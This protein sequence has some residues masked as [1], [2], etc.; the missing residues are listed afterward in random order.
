MNPRLAGAIARAES[1]LASLATIESVVADLRAVASGVSGASDRSGAPTSALAD[2]AAP[3]AESIESDQRTDGSW[4]GSL[5][6]TSLTLLMIR[7]LR[8]ERTNAV[9]RAIE[10]V[11]A[12]SEGDG[13]FGDLPGFFSPAPPSIDLSS[14]TLP[15]GAAIGGD[16]DAR[17]AVSCLACAAVVCWG[18]RGPNI[19]SH[20]REAERLVQLA[21][22]GRAEI[23]LPALLCAVR[24]FCVMDDSSTGSADVAATRDAALEFVARSQRGDGSWRGADLFL[25]LD[26]LADAARSQKAPTA[27]Y[28]AL[29]HASDTLF[30]MQQQ[31]GSWGRQTG[32]VQMLAGLSALRALHN[33][34]PKVLSEI[35]PI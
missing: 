25:V 12:R 19:D 22:T 5:L 30:M 34:A 4:A 21:I 29:R 20:L 15:G 6:E 8:P 9:D 11:F 23:S 31:D 3:L 10:W 33:G 7:E 13:R 14:M 18:E 16:G 32:P 17:M 1:H 28:V 35:R 2:L 27:V 24:L 26:V